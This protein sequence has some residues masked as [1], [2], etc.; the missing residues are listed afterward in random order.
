MLFPTL[1]E[2]FSGTYIEAM[3]FGLPIITSDLDFAHTV[4]GDAAIYCDP[5]S[6]K[7]IRDAI[8]RLKKSPVLCDELVEKGYKRLKKIGQSWDDIVT[9]ALHEIEALP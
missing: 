1:L 3:H 2:S 5:L 9:T 6:I 4:C 8:L 7:S